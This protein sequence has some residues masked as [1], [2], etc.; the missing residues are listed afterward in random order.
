MLNLWG[1]C[2]NVNE[3]LFKF[4]LEK[5]IFNFIRNQSLHCVKFDDKIR[6]GCCP[7]VSLCCRSS[8][9]V[10]V[11]CTKLCI[12]I[13]MSS[14]TADQGKEGQKGSRKV[15]SIVSGNW[16]SFS[17]A[18]I[19]CCLLSAGY[20]YYGECTTHHKLYNLALRVSRLPFSWRGRDQGKE[21]KETLGTRVEIVVQIN[22]VCLIW[23]GARLHQVASRTVNITFR[24]LGVYSG[25][26]TVNITIVFIDYI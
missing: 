20:L 11:K 10:T 12:F 1:F 9:F 19:T 4:F 16:I 13:F 17:V 5:V 7:N 18:V 22:V 26:A 23:L 21:R 25:D 15:T 8:L 14:R 2:Y 24:M 3:R 6:T